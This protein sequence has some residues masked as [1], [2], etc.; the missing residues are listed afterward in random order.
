MREWLLLSAF[1]TGGLKVR[2]GRAPVA[3]VFSSTP[4]VRERV[5]FAREV[6]NV[7]DGT[8]VEEKSG[9]GP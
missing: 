2:E 9:D 8:Q 1:G 4:D 7:G 3:I 5:S 6:K